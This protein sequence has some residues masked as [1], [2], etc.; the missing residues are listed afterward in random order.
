MK[1][2]ALA[3]VLRRIEAMGIRG[4]ERFWSRIPPAVARRL[5]PRVARVG[6]AVLTLGAGSDALRMNRVIG[7]GHRAR[8]RESMIDEIIAFYRSARLRRFSLMMSPGPQSARITAW[9]LA[10]GFTPGGGHSLLLRDARRS[11]PAAHA[12][13]RPSVRVARARR[14][15]A[16]AIIAIHERCF[17]L[18]AS[19]RTWMRAALDDR[20]LEQYLAWV[21]STP[22]ATGALRVDGDLAW[23]GGGA[24]L[25]RWRRRGAH[26]AL[27]AA[28][29]RRAAAL[30]CRWVCVETVMPAPGR[31]TGSRRNLLRAG[32][33]EACLKPIFVWHER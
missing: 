16:G 14:N 12:G 8:V 20:G 2:P 19:R 3:A 28:R 33:E 29:L 22:V 6:D 31:P 24:T 10:R 9:L 15:D 7:L 5:R 26:G 30:G 13:V 1:A 21:G 11:L 23:L 32:F 25:T 4:T 18:P 17:A 27:I